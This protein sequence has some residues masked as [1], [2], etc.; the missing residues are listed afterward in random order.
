MLKFIINLFK[1]KKEN[2][3]IT[4]K[5]TAEDVKN[6]YEEW[7]D[8]YLESFGS[9]F[10]SAQMQNQ[11]QLI[12]HILELMQLP[13]NSLLLD[14]G[15]GV[16]GPAIKFSKLGNLKVEGITISAKQTATAN[17][18]ISK[19]K[20]KIIEGDFHNLS[21]YYEKNYFDAIVFLESLVHSSNPKKVLEEAKKVLKKNGLIYIKDLFTRK[22]TPKKEK[23]LVKIAENNT[24]KYCVLEI[25]PSSEIISILK[26][27]NFELLVYNNLENTMNHDIG[28]AFVL[29]N[30]I[31]IYNGNNAVEYLEWAELIFKNNG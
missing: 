22:N 18:L 17:E 11:N 3:L 20:V 14:A 29:K 25:K 8:K 2:N 4:Q 10:Q 12:K 7:H 23:E 30:Q 1:K 5:I 13:K 21:N 26:D 24:N 6:Y 15:C 9:F 16:G 31:D 19:N 27:L 28:N